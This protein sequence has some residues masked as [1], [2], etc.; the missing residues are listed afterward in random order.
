[1]ETCEA[2]NLPRVIEACMVEG[3]GV[4]TVV[5]RLDPGSLVV[6][7]C[8]GRGWLLA[9]DFPVQYFNAEGVYVPLELYE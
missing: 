2:G 4:V 3:L 6:C 5:R 1:M 7:D 9:A 8:M